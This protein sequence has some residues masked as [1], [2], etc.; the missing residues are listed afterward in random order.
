M[1]ILTHPYIAHATFV[2]LGYT[3]GTVANICAE[4][5]AH[6]SLRQT[7]EPKQMLGTF[8]K[9]IALKWTL[10]TILTLLTIT[11]APNQA[12]WTLVGIVTSVL[13]KSRLTKLIEK[14]EPHHTYSN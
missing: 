14:Y 7:A 9:S 12:H 6:Q 11:N 3:I 5:I 2:T 8:Y 13:T 10:F 1:N 4:Q